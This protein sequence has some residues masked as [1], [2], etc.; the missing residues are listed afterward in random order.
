M[1]VVGCFQMLASDSYIHTYITF[2]VICVR[3]SINPSVILYNVSQWQSPVHVFL[4]T[5]P[6]DKGPDRQTNK[7]VRG[8]LKSAVDYQ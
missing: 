8:G 4:A 6:Q 3:C 1:F 7:P 2:S 5:Y